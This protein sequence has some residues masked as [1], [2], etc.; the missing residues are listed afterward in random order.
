MDFLTGSAERRLNF[1]GCVM[2]IYIFSR[3]Y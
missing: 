1:I 3:P 2:A